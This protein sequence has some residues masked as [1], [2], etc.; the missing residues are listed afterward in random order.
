MYSKRTDHRGNWQE[1]DSS[2]LLFLCQVCLGGHVSIDGIVN[3]M[4]ESCL[5]H[6]GFTPSRSNLLCYA[7]EILEFICYDRYVSFPLKFST[8]WLS[9]THNVKSNCLLKVN[10]LY[11]LSLF[12]KFWASLIAQL[13]KSPPAMQETLVWFLGWKDPQEKE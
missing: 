13:V 10:W 5:T 9:P 3:N 2:H 1:C 8:D 4:E 7:P 11:F 12:L 6:V